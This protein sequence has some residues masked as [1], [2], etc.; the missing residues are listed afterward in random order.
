MD[1]AGLEGPAGV[2]AVHTG[3]GHNAVAAAVH[4]DRLVRMAAL[5]THL[6]AGCNPAGRRILDF[7]SLG[8]IPG[9]DHRVLPGAGRHN[10]LGYRK[11]QT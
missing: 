6:A 9:P 1:P 2:A 8:C 7:G 5:G 10:R 3:P 4:T 11:V